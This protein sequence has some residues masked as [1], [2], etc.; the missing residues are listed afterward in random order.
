MRIFVTNGLEAG[1]LSLIRSRG[2]KLRSPDPK[3]R[4]RDSKRGFLL[5][6][7][8]HTHLCTQHIPRGFWHANTL[9]MGHTAIF[10]L[11]SCSAS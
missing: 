1:I 11:V 3:L 2:P 7:A 6:T 10:G 4:S 9:L 5:R 8:C